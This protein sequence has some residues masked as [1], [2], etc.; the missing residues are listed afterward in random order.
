MFRVF[1]DQDRSRVLI[2]VVKCRNRT[3]DGTF[4]TLLQ[5]DHLHFLDFA[6]LPGTMTNALPSDMVNQELEDIRQVFLGL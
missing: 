3:P 6:F 2:D 1:R 5:F 4:M